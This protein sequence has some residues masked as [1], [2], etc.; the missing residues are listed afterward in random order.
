M[1]LLNKKPEVINS[2]DMLL[3]S[4]DGDG[5]IQDGDIYYFFSNSINRWFEVD[6]EF[7]ATNR[8]DWIK[9]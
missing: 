1:R 8:V 5:L 9:G 6:D 2:F 3:F 4:N 7:M